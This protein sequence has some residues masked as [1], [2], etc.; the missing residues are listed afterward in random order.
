MEIKE[1]LRGGGATPSEGDLLHN[2]LSAPRPLSREDSAEDSAW[3]K[4]PP[5]WLGTFDSLLPH[6]A[7]GE[8]VVYTEKG[9]AMPAPAGGGTN[10]EAMEE[11]ALAS[12][13]CAERMA[14]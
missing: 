14:H 4:L 12:R 10:Q 7:G 13:L 6:E 5:A 11:A 1:L 8:L 3:S 2:L 9:P